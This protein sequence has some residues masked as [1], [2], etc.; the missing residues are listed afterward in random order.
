MGGQ[1]VKPRCG[2]HGPGSERTPNPNATQYCGTWKPRNGPD[3][4]VG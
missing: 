2:H 4:K 3:R 1:S